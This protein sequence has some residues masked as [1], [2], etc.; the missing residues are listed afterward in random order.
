MNKY[1]KYSQV[2]S[3]SVVHKSTVHE[4][5]SVGNSVGGVDDRGGV[6]EGG[7][8]VVGNG[9]DGGSVGND[10]LR[11]GSGAVVGDLGDISVNGVGVVVHMLDPAVGK[12]DRVRA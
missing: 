12:G 5:G 7:N 10:S 11:V 3:L 4:G 6:D 1:H 8:S 9:V 2:F